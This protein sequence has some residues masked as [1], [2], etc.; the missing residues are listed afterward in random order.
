MVTILTSIT[1]Y[2]LVFPNGRK[3]HVK[4]MW[5]AIRLRDYWNANTKLLPQ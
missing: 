5:T 4:N 1:G 3:R 2:T